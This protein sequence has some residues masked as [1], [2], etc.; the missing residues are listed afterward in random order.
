M[1]SAL[2]RRTR[3]VYC[4]ARAAA[5]SAEGEICE[6]SDARRDARDAEAPVRREARR[7]LV[8]QVG[9]LLLAVVVQV[10][11]LCKKFA[12]FDTISNDT[13]LTITKLKN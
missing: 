4:S 3:E 8:P 6:P 10:H 1:F 11:I 2:A 9:L 12:K 13:T 7:Q 5:A